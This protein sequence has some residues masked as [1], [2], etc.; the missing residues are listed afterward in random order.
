M[1]EYHRNCTVD[2]YGCGKCTSKPDGTV[3]V[4]SDPPAMSADDCAWVFEE[5]TYARI[6]DTGC[7]TCTWMTEVEC[8]PGWVFSPCSERKDAA[9]DLEC[10]NATKPVRDSVW[11]KTLVRDPETSIKLLDPMPD[12]RPDADIYPNE[13]CMWGCKEKK[14]PWKSAGGLWF[15]IDE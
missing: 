5:G 11:L 10:F 4:A 2:G 14:K 8:P 6:G 3:Y 12:T 1:D 15:C 7:T 9:C 13:G